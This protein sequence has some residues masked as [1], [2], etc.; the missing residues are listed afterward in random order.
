MRCPYCSQRA[1]C[2][3]D[4]QE[5]IDQMHPHSSVPIVCVICCAQPWGDPSYFSQNFHDHL[6]NR[7]AGE[8]GD[9][10]P[11]VQKPDDSVL[12]EDYGGEWSEGDVIGCGVRNGRVFFAR[13]GKSL[14]ALH[15]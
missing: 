10:S 14:G 2:E 15:S 9:G 12:Q 7:H 5:H 8:R 11:M 4:V 1:L 3:T 13:N 6:R